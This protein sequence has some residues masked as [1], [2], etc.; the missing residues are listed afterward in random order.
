MYVLQSYPHAAC[1]KVTVSPQP[2]QLL[3]PKEF[4]AGFQ[5]V[6]G[7]MKNELSIFFTQH[8]NP[9]DQAAAL[10]ANAPWSGVWGVGE[11]CVSRF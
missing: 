8:P 7:L 1:K 2:C 10:L 6:D 3:Q 11:A 4:T 5:N 9:N